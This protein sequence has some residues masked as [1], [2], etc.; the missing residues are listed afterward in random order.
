[1]FL[2]QET[3]KTLYKGIVEPHFRYCCSVWCCA[4]LNELNQLQKLQNRAARILTNSSVDTP[5]RL[6]I[7]RLDW[8]T[9][10]QLI[11]VEPK[12][13]VYKSMHEMA[14]PYLC[15]LFIK[16][17]TSSSHVLRNTATDLKLPKKCHVMGRDGFLIDELKCGMTFMQK[18]N[19]HLL[20]MFSKSLFKFFM[21]FLSSFPILGFIYVIRF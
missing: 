11:A 17:S 16:N 15:D 12:T 8:K 20:W 21:F 5:G 4:S 13:M 14:P 10:D 3:L 7:D 6:L 18:L 1:M 2:P 9:I 19:R